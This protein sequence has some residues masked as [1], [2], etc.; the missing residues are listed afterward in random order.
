MIVAT[1]TRY[2][3]YVLHSSKFNVE[4]LKRII[5]LIANLFAYTSNRMV[6]LE[7]FI[8]ST[9]CFCTA[10]VVNLKFGYTLFSG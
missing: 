1:L 10:C 9:A 6:I 5:P 2:S 4:V 3:M 7:I 8:R